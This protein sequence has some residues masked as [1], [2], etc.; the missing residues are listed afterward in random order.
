M[1]LCLAPITTLNEN[2]FAL[3]VN[4]ET[5]AR[6][7]AELTAFLKAK[8]GKATY[9]WATA[10]ALAASVIYTQAS[11][12]DIV[13]EVTANLGAHVYLFPEAQPR[14]VSMWLKNFGANGPVIVTRN[15]KA[16]AVLL[17]V[18]DEEEL[19]RLVLAHSPKFQALLDKS[20]QQIEETGG[21]PHEQFWREVEAETRGTTKNGARGGRRTKRRT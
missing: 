18:T 7:V 12:V 3:I 4:P 6:S 8:N 17:A 21:I 16:V 5:P 9:G 20:R 14:T 19:E 15:G 10:I 2:G 1:G 11:N 13:P